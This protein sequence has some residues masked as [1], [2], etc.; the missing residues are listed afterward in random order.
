M[1]SQIFCYFKKQSLILYSS[2]AKSGRLSLNPLV[3]IDSSQFYII[4]ILKDQ[5]S[6]FVKAI[7]SFF[8]VGP[9][10]ILIPCGASL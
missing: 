2:I 1:R 7:K 8:I 10:H 5:S 9:V 4:N 6:Q 3:V